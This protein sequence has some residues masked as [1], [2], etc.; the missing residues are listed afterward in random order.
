MTT[1]RRTPRRQPP[2]PSADCQARGLEKKCPHFGAGMGSM[3]CRIH[4]EQYPSHCDPQAWSVALEAPLEWQTCAIYLAADRDRWKKMAERLENE[5]R[6]WCEAHDRW[7]KIADGL[8][9]ESKN[10]DA[11]GYGHSD[12]I[13]ERGCYCGLCVALREYEEA[14]KCP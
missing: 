5:V 11:E 1:K 8:A 9:R 14:G 2:P 4:G 12:T 10:A 3:R 6:S 7:R 13:P